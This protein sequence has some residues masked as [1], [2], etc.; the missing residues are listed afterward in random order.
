MKKGDLIVMGEKILIVTEETSD[1]KSVPVIH[2]TDKTAD[3]K[4][5]VVFDKINLE[6]LEFQVIRIKLRS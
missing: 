1:T 4:E 6:N 2:N 3:A 5:G